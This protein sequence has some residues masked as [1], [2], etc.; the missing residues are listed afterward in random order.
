[1]KSKKKKKSKEFIWHEKK[2]EKKSKEFIWLHL[3]EKVPKK[4]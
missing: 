4:F 3:W 2:K 1:M